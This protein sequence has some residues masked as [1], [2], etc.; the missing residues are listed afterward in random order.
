MLLTRATEPPVILIR[1]SNSFVSYPLVI[2]GS[3]FD[4]ASHHRIWQRA[5]TT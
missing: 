1:L 4:R 2:V 5:R 3:Y